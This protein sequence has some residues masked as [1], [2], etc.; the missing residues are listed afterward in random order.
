MNKSKSIFILLLTIFCLTAFSSQTLKIGEDLKNA[1]NYVK[2][3]KYL[4]P[5]FEKQYPNIKVR[6][7]QVDSSVIGIRY[8]LTQSPA[9]ADVYT[10]KEDINYFHSLFASKLISEIPELKNWD[11]W[12]KFYPFVKK[13]SGLDGKYFF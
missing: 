13:A 5:I 8:M 1:P 4:I 10:S 11:Q 12:K 2:W 6:L 9:I 7:V 3:Y